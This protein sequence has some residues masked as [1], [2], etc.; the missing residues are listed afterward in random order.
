MKDILKENKLKLLGIGII[1]YFVFIYAININITIKNCELIGMILVAFIILST[2]FIIVKKYEKEKKIDYKKII[3]A[4]IIIGI[5]LRTVYILYTP[6]TQRQHDMEVETGHLAYIETIYQTGKL[7]TSNSWQFYQ[8]P[9]HHIIA[10]GWLKINEFFSVDLQTAEEGIQILTAIYSSMLMLITYCILK[11]IKIKDCYKVLVILMIAVHPTFIILSGSINNDILSVMLIF[12]NLL[13]IVKWYKESS[14]KNTIILAIITALSAL[15]KIAGTIIAVPILYVFINKLLK[16]YFKEKNV[17]VIKSYIS[18]FLVFVI[19]SLGLGLSYSIRNLILFDQDIFYVPTPGE[20][21]YCGDRSW[22]DRL[23]I[24]SSE[25]LNI[26]CKPFDDCNIFAYLIKSSLFGEYSPE[27]TDIIGEIIAILMLISNII[28]V[29]ISLICLIKILKKQKQKVSVIL[30]MFIIFYIT[31]LAMY[32]YGNVTKQY[33]CTMDF[34]Y[35]VPTILLGMLFIIN[36]CKESKKYYKIVSSM[37]ILFAIV[38]IIFEL[39]YM[40]T[41]HL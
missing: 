36:I 12:T 37:V 23:N 3:L 28:I 38:A 13:Y 1:L 10:A 19:I 7:P 33:G 39:T 32:M 34:R 15:T 40:S 27:Q 30:K 9:L 26:Y 21:S 4:I 8:Q 25:W 24:F 20:A 31:E 29:T 35:I 11:E 17:Q 22:L 2:N 5:I 16:D 6:I 14:F 18:K 41:L